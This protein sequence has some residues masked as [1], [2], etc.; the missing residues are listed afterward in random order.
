MTAIV[1]A[2][3]FVLLGGWGLVEWF[4]E[5][6]IVAKGFLPV[7]LVIGGVVAVVAGV[8]ALRPARVDEKELN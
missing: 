3:I 4:P 2:A 7:S 1:V 8:S 6:V 5:L